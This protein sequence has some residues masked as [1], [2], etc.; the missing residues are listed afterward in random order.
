MKNIMEELAL[1]LTADR[2]PFA[3]IYDAVSEQLLLLIFKARKLALD[4]AWH[5]WFAEQHRLLGILCAKK[6]QLAEIYKHDSYVIGEKEKPVDD[7]L[8]ALILMRRL[9]NGFDNNQVS[10]KTWGQINKQPESWHGRFS[11]SLMAESAFINDELI[12]ILIKAKAGS[13]PIPAEVRQ[14]YCHQD[15][16]IAWSRA[17]L[18]I[19]KL[20]AWFAIDPLTLLSEAVFQLVYLY[21]NQRPA[22]PDWLSRFGG[23][24]IY[25]PVPT[26][27][28]NPGFTE[29]NKILKQH[30]R[31]F[32]RDV[33]SNAD[34]REAEHLL[35]LYRN[36]AA[37]H[38][39]DWLWEIMA[40]LKT[41]QWMPFLWKLCTVIPPADANKEENDAQPWNDDYCQITILRENL[42]ELIQKNSLGEATRFLSDCLMR[43]Y[44]NAAA[45]KAQGLPASISDEEKKGY[46]SNHYL[47][48]PP[49]ELA[50]ERDAESVMGF[51]K[52]YQQNKVLLTS[53]NVKRTEKVSVEAWLAGLKCFDLK[54]GIP[55]GD[56]MKIKDGVYEKIKN[57]KNLKMPK[58]TSPNSL[59]R[60]H[61]RVKE[62]ISARIDT[63]IEQ[64]QT[65]NQL[66]PYSGARDA[67]KP[68][69]EKSPIR[70][71]DR[72]DKE[73]QISDPSDLFT[74]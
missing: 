56:A 23:V 20:N 30:K 53:H 14:G 51:E 1:T 50:R 42:L 36:A 39:C 26:I 19:E 58:G 72:T 61:N 41:P 73:Q 37:K 40:Y 10:I 34:E 68:L 24:H 38:V 33:Q 35:D 71:P 16:S 11:H 66:A 70:S 3:E 7:V 47:F 18:L 6:E 29:I 45:N 52:W 4:P 46:T 59:Q 74:Q 48:T 15:L 63:L 27:S 17:D 12:E 57:D 25:N 9:F 62:V 5:G 13:E 28:D 2:P 55:N 43:I 22:L 49:R 64:Q 44:R 31:Q 60:Y 8:Y 32:I 69:W 21:R 54:R 65:S 67:F